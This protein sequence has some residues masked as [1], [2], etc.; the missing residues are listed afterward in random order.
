MPFRFDRDRALSFT[1]FTWL[2][3]VDDKC[4]ETAGALS[5]TTLVS[6]VPLTVSVTNVAPTVEI[7]GADSVNEGS[8]YSL[9][10]KPPTDPGTDTLTSY[11]VHWGD[12]T[13]SLIRPAAAV[14]HTYSGAAARTIDTARPLVAIA[15]SVLSTDNR[16]SRS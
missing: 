14:T 3:F 9:T 2:R 16:S 5:Y 7:S 11:T 6:L 4:F 8:T 13:Q 10:L 1:R 15:Y 12:G